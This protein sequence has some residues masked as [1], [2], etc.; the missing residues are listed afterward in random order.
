MMRID[1][2][3]VPLVIIPVFAL[4]LTIYLCWRYLLR[5]PSLETIEDVLRDTSI[6]SAWERNQPLPNTPSSASAAEEIE[7]ASRPSSVV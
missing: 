4:F 6:S 7:M 5:H 1:L 2:I 3:P